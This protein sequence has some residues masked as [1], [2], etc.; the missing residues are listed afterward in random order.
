VTH[1][2]RPLTLKP[3]DYRL[4]FQ[5]VRSRPAVAFTVA[6]MLI[7]LLCLAMI[8]VDRSMGGGRFVA[9]VVRQYGFTS[10]DDQLAAHA[11]TLVAV[12]IFSVLVFILARYGAIHFSNRTIAW[13]PGALASTVFFVFGLAVYSFWLPGWLSIYAAILD[14]LFAS[15]VVAA[16]YLSVRAINL[17]T[18][19]LI[20]AYLAMLAVPGFLVNPIP[21]MAADPV[22]LSQFEMHVLSLTMPGHAIVAGLNFFDQVP[23]GYGLLSPSIMS[24]I[25][26][27]KH[28]M[29]IG[30][31]LRFVQVWQFLFSIAAVGAYFS[32]RSQNLLGILLA[33]LLAG[34]YWVTA[35]LGIWHPN[36]TGLRSIGLP[37]G[38]LAI[39][40][41]G[42]FD[43]TRAAWWLGGV[44]A[45]VL[46]SNV[47][48][49]I[50]IMIGFAVYFVVRTNKV[51]IKPAIHAVAA[52]ISVLLAYG[53]LYGI[54][55]GRLP[56]ALR[57]HNF[58]DVA[59]QFARVS[60]GGD[61][62]RLFR[63]GGENEGLYLI[64]FAL[65]MF[66][67]AIY[68]VISAFMKL[69]CRKLTQREAV[70][71]AVAAILLVW[72]SYYFNAPNWWQIWTHLFLY[73]FLIIDVM[74]RRLFA[75]GFPPQA[76]QN[77]AARLRHLRIAPTRLVLLF[78]L[79]LVIVHTN[80]HLLKYTAEFMYPDW[81]R[82]PHDASIVSDILL[83]KEMA[84]ALRTKASKLTELNGVTK[85][86]LIYLTFNVAFMPEL[87]GLFERN[88]KRDLWVGIPGDAAF[89]ATM[90]TILRER[91]DIMLIDA[92]TGPLAVTGARKDFQDRVR[93]AI[94]RRYQLSATE[95]GWQIWRPF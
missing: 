92:P 18:G 41:A 9:E 15:F 68:V 5:A 33:M 71:V 36:Q 55:L 22:A 88:P 80:R 11:F 38:V 31:Q 28:N 13:K 12:A 58:F 10:S 34:P 51:P 8:P 48:T 67:H 93:Q 30:N 44:A 50:A 94:G 17:V 59:N 83:P 27:I 85:G 84:E 23:S 91:P 54:A 52:F 76:A 75:I 29:T 86:S 61:G 1:S 26:T 72:L 63:S 46:L 4:Y 45:I 73:G 35:G 56:M 24:V 32:F 66:G 39:A 65:I 53:V 81:V 79:G 82:V 74:D 95:D 14:I 90:E 19:G 87:T 49:S 3:E 21:L 70:R 6:A 57:L 77:M 25:D 69:G 78:F 37:L 47:E 2:L 40:L 7:F 20:G 89:D 42:R 60:Q 43:V 62:L 64:P 16:P